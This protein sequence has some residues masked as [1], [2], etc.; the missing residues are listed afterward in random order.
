MFPERSSWGRRRSGGAQN[1]SIKVGRGSETQRGKGSE[2]A[3]G[4]GLP[5][6]RE[7]G[8]VPE[9]LRDWGRDLDAHLDIKKQAMRWGASTGSLPTHRSLLF[10]FLKQH[11]CLTPI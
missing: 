11:S 2:R 10:S 3:P 8:R 7:A 6:G 5:E 1:R 4:S 9:G